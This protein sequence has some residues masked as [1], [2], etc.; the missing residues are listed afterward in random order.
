MATWYWFGNICV[1][2]CVCVCVW[3]CVCVHVH[4]CIQKSCALYW[5]KKIN[6]HKHLQLTCNILRD[7]PLTQILDIHCNIEYMNK[8][9][10]RYTVWGHFDQN[11][12]QTFVPSDALLA[13]ARTVRNVLLQ[14]RLEEDL[15]WIVPHV[16]PMTKLVKG[17]NWTEP[18]ATVTLKLS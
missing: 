16:P 8:Y 1:C 10:Q 9:I 2:V 5:H 6:L 17:L 12:L 15:C 11:R 13:H 14:E 4:A 7:M 18:D 3:V